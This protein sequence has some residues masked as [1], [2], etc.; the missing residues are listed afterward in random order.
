MKIMINNNNRKVIIAPLMNYII[1][2]TYG[3]SILGG[4]V[5]WH[6]PVK[7]QSSQSFVRL[8]KLKPYLQYLHFIPSD[9]R[10][11]AEILHVPSMYIME[12]ESHNS[13]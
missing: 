9:S 4:H 12:A 5:F 13:H 8:L 7:V 11:P 1:Y 6:F 2:S 3:A 10:H